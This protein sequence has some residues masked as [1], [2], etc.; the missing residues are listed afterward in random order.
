MYISRRAHNKNITACVISVTNISGM[1]NFTLV[2]VLSGILLLSIS[3][4]SCSKSEADTNKPIESIAGQWMINRV[5][6][7]LYYGAVF[8][9]DTI[10][11]NGGAYTVNFNNST[12]AFSYKYKSPVTETGT[13]ITKGTDSVIA[14]TSTSTY[15]WKMLTLTDVL[16]TARNTSNNDPAFPGATVETYY[17]FVR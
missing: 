16:F 2:T 14:T 11:S 1:K 8:Y 12:Q 10:I 5:Q 9:K 3:I 6:L 13:Y 15:R 4:T 17:T 7:K